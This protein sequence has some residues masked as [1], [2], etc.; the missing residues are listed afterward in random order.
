MT[1]RERWCSC[2]VFPLLCGEQIQS[3]HFQSMSLSKYDTSNSALADHAVSG[4]VGDPMRT[5]P[6]GE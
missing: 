6:F 1:E 4:E 2:L 5:G 3:D